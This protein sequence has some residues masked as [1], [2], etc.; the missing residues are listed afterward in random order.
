MEERS[1]TRLL[2]SLGE[3]SKNIDF[4][5]VVASK[6]QEETMS[7]FPKAEVSVV[8]YSQNNVQEAITG[9]RRYDG[10]YSPLYFIF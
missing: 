4:G 9:S 1:L 8:R 3:K 7:S 6:F 5:R 10:E 2:S